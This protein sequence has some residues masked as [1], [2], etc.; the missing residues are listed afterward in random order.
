MHRYTFKMARNTPVCPE[1]RA[2]IKLKQHTNINKLVRETG[3]SKA[4]IYRIWKKPILKNNATKSRKGVG[5]RPQKLT[6]RDKQRI[7][8]TINI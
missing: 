2:Y 6:Q 5:G 1:T 7:T 8:R 4:T 3:V